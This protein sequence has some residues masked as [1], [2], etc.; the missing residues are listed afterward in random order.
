MREGACQQLPARARQM[1][2]RVEESPR[3]TNS[4]SQ[5][6]DAYLGWLC[7]FRLEHSKQTRSQAQ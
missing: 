3:K 5:N 4:T 7:Y 6:R 2:Q 1:I